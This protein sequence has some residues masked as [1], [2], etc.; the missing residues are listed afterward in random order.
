MPRSSLP[1]I[2]SLSKGSFEP[3][4]NNP[5][6]ILEDKPLGDELIPITIG[7]E[8]TPI[9]V[10]KDNIRFTS[11]TKIESTLEVD[12]KTTLDLLEARDLDIV[13]GEFNVYQEGSTTNKLTFSFGGDTGTSALILGATSM[14][15]STSAG[16]LVLN[17]T[18]GDAKFNSDGIVIKDNGD[19]DTPASGY[20]T[21]YVNSDVLY[22][23]TDGGTATNLLSGGG[24]ASA[25]DDL[26]DVTY[27]S[28]DLTISSLDTIIT[29]TCT[30]DSSGYIHLDA[31]TYG[32][33]S[34][35]KTGTTFADLLVFGSKS[36]FD[37]Y[38]EGDSSTND[39][40]QITVAEHGESTIITKDT[41]A[42]AAHLK[43]EPDGSFLIKET[44]SA[45]ADVAGYGQIWIKDDTPNSIYFTNDGGT[46]IPLNRWFY[47]TGARFYT[48][49][50][51]WYYPSV[52]YGVNSVN[53]S[54]SFNSSSLT[55]S[56]NDS[57]NPILVMSS[58]IVLTSYH[59]YGNFS[60]TETYELALL[61]GTGVTYG[62]AGNFTVS[63]IGSTQSVS[64]TGS[65]YYKLEETG[66]SA[67][68]SAGDTIIPALRRTTT[69]T[70]SYR[71]FEFSMSLEGVYV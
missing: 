58:D 29:G 28:G 14:N 2:K 19:V 53:W 24:G 39:Y 33:T 71:Y 4:K 3:R 49:Y 54:S 66:L 15:I 17:A 30:W 16:D 52:V 70:S 51:N 18:G 25:L 6:E 32:T 31:T 60:S 44:S 67:S 55:T 11:A 62:S 48:R 45:G 43:F 47:N 8:V 68:L 21:L 46:D 9:E 63:Q 38:S 7:K 13:G 42:A 40:F 27:S 1:N 57:Y 35:K 23:K 50:D 36:I 5:I 64:A 41:A 59:F 34:F 61:K 22:F 26:S 69:D 12:G 10:A 20:G 37:L 56:W 65:R